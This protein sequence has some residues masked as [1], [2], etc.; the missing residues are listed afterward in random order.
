MSGPG[1]RVTAGAGTPARIE[2]LDA[3]RGL[4]VLGIL[5][6]NAPF[7]AA[8]F[9]QVVEPR[10]WPFAETGA[11]LAL[12]AVVH[13]FFDSRFITLF[14]LLFGVSTWLVGGD[15]GDAAG[16]ARLRRR[17]AWLA[18]FG[19]LHGA[20]VWYGDVLLDYA[21]CGFALMA[22]RGWTAQRLIAAGTWGYVAGV[23]LMTLLPALPAVG[24]LLQPAG[25][26]L[27][28][29]F[30]HGFAASLRANF[31]AWAGHRASIAFYTLP[32]CAP[33]MLLGLGLFKAGALTGA[34][35]ARL[36]RAAV[37]AGAAGLACIAASTRAYVRGGFADPGWDSL[38][39]YA[40][41][42]FVTLGYASALILAAR[43]PRLRRIVR[44]LAPLG[45]M[46]FT[47][48]LMQSVLMTALFYGGRGPG[49]F[50]RVDRPGLALAVLSVWALQ[51]AWSHAWL[52]RFESG[53]LEWVW[54]CLTQGRVGPLRRA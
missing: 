28:A 11:S 50:G 22:L 3:L 30:Q 21:A 45:R 5:A 25:V 43:S 36:H 7:M 44:A 13:V 14:A 38:V 17:F 24:A 39:L 2:L 26:P 18:V 33:L 48:Y 23:A 41:G 6:V 16:R 42:P 37:I 34:V 47:N 40:A 52:R 1:G 29:D 27:P 53:P 8:G 20:F 9:E 12:W 19:L 49:L 35:P 51:L 32:Y 4:G 46:A 54:R 31:A 15:P 10:A